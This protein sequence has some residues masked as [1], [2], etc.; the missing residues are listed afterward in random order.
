MRVIRVIRVIRVEEAV[1]GGTVLGAETAE[2]ALLGA[3]IFP[4]AAP[5]LA[6]VPEVLARQGTLEQLL[7]VLD[8]ILQGG[9]LETQEQAATAAVAAVAVVPSAP[10]VF[11]GGPE[12]VQPGGQV[13]Q[14]PVRRPAAVPP[15]D[16]VAAESRGAQAVVAEGG[17]L[18]QMGAEE[19]PAGG[20]EAR[21]AREDLVLPLPITRLAFLARIQSLL[22][23]GG[24]LT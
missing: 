12:E 23:A 3:V 11:R 5:V 15:A 16:T 19:G 13:G 22:A 20:R 17:L 6:A 10:T 9:T 24:L 8:I 7:Q 14:L 4:R 1:E 2:G 21:E 18:V